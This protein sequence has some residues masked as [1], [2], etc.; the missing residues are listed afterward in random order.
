MSE[1]RVPKALA[2]VREEND[3]SAAGSRGARWRSKRERADRASTLVAIMFMLAIAFSAGLLLVYIDGGQTQLEGL[4][5]FGA[6]A[7]MGSGLAIWVKV[8]IDEPQ[9]V[10]H[11]DLMSEAE[12][13]RTNRSW[14]SARTAACAAARSRIDWCTV[15]TAVYHVGVYAR[16]QSNTR[17][18]TKPGVQ[19][20]L[21]PPAM[22]AVSAAISPWM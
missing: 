13:D 6:F 14:R 11:R 12:D 21:A 19:T 5:L 4:L 15:G 3:V 2:D 22:D 9:V 20:A 8:I 17:V 16:I 7:A 18:A 1:P 10:E